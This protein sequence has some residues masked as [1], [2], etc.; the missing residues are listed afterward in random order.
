VEGAEV[1][2]EAAELMDSAGA[3]VVADR[4]VATPVGSAVAEAVAAAVRNS[5]RG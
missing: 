1:P 4:A 5:K 2:V 3:V